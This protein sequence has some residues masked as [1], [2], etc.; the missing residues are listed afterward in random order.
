MI[1]TIDVGNT[2]I[3]L[4]C[5]DGD[6]LKFVSRMKTDRDKMRDEY[7]VAIKALLDYYNCPADHIDGVILSTVVPPLLLT[8]K[9][10]LQ[11]LTGCRVLTVGPGTKTGLDIRTDDPS[12][13]GADLVCGAVGA[14]GRHPLPCVVID[15]GTATK[16]SVLDE[17]G[18]FLGCTILPG[19]M[20]SLDAL[21]R[22][23][24]QLPH[25]ELDHMDH[26]VCTNTLE[27]MRAGILYGTGSMIDGILAQI[28]AELG[29]SV[30]PVI[31]GGLAK[32]FLA[33]C[34]RELV[35]DEYLLLYGLKAIYDKNA[36]RPK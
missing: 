32:R 25:I 33:Y 5:F 15:L 11:R 23:T 28:E 4:G 30:T 10:A 35:Y 3:V 8:L 34:K 7:A 36:K 31:T 26:V 12:A 27:C 14:I 29:H 6:E 21:S 1:L 19:V 9:A 13:L 17:K 24:A 16:F 2:N 20:I 18:V 22:Q